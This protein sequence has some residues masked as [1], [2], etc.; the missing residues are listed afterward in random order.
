MPLERG[1][2]RLVVAGRAWP[3][4]IRNVSIGGYGV[5]LR[6]AANLGDA[7][8]AVL[9]TSDGAI[10]VRIV[11]ISA[12]SKTTRLGLTRVD[13]P[14]RQALAEEQARRF[15]SYQLALL[16]AA[17]VFFAGLALVERSSEHAPSRHPPS[18]WQTGR[19][20]GIGATTSGSDRG[21]ASA[22]GSSSTLLS[23]SSLGGPPSFSVP[24]STLGGHTTN[25]PAAVQPPSSGSGAVLT[26]WRGHQAASGSGTAANAAGSRAAMSSDGL[27]ANRSSS[28]AATA[29]KP[30][31][32][33]AQVLD[34]LARLSTAAAGQPTARQRAATLDALLTEIATVASEPPTG[35]AQAV[36]RDGVHIEYRSTG[37]ALEVLR[38]RVD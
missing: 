24:K 37:E 2:G 25:R 30:V 7:E 29:G 38:V 22:G 12:L 3:C 31:R 1:Q 11:H 20:L 35:P 6:E 4:V 17:A 13:E 27:V 5:E 28:A 10:P 16:A 9:E 26:N 19:A 8:T 32:L 18:L 23:P 34:E 15:R 33:A 36:S 21:T 14:D